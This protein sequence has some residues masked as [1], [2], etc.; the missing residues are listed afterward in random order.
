MGRGLI[1]TFLD[2]L[3]SG[4]LGPF[5]FL[6]NGILNGI[7]VGFSLMVIAGVSVGF[8]VLA[9]P[10]PERGA[11]PIRPLY[12]ISIFPTLFL[13]IWVPVWPVLIA[14][15]ICVGRTLYEE[16]DHWKGSRFIKAY[17]REMEE[18]VRLVKEAE[19]VSP[20]AG[21][22]CRALWREALDATSGYGAKGE[23][24]FFRSVAQNMEEIID[25]DPEREKLKRWNDSG[26][27]L[28]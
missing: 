24:E 19:H 8:W 6:W 4:D 15:A 21:K 26:I 3:A 28:S 27:Q 5:L 1:R 2:A 18:L 16:Y 17:K 23:L 7:L 22:Q 12:V 20:E 14:W 10:E 9:L 25:L 13:L 11:R